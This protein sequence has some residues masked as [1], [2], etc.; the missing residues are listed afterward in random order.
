ML[1]PKPVMMLVLA[2]LLSLVLVLPAMS[3]EGKIAKIDGSTISLSVE[4]AMPP[5]VQKGAL[6]NTSSG[7]GKV[8]AV[9]EN[10]VDLKVKSSEAAK[11]KVGEVVDVKPKNA[12]AGQKLQ[13]C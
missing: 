9:A 7:L 6:A 13:G 2:L 1:M 10:S 5:W 8:A 4:G 3:F 12:A 11:L